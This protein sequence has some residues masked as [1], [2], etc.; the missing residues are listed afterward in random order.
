MCA[1]LCG[2]PAVMNNIIGVAPLFIDRQ[3]GRK[4]IATLRTA[5]FSI[6]VMVIGFMACTAIIFI[7]GRNFLPSLYINDPEVIEI[8]AGLLVIAGFFQLSDGIQVVSLGALRGLE[9][10]RIPT[11]VTFISYWVVALPLGYTLGFVADMGPKGIWIGLLT[12]LTLTA[13]FL[14]IRFNK[15]TRKMLVKY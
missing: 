13:V 4:D 8:A 6:F 11:L 15:L 12:G 10:V 5:A 9:D 2:T 14:L 7:I 3:L 1:G